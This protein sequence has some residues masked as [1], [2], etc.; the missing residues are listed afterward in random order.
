MKA[1][2]NVRLSFLKQTVLVL[3]AIAVLEYLFLLF[4]FAGVGERIQHVMSGLRA[5]N[6]KFYYDSILLTKEQIV[7]L[8]IR[9]EIFNHTHTGVKNE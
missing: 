3:S 9:R 4:Y 5:Y 8:L 7:L 1:L 6:N 2:D